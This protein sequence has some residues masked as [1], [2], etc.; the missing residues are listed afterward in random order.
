MYSD[1][2][3]ISLHRCPSGLCFVRSHWTVVC[4][5]CEFCTYE[6]LRKSQTCKCCNWILGFPLLTRNLQKPPVSA[7]WAHQFFQCKSNTDL[8]RYHRLPWTDGM[9]LGIQAQNNLKVLPSMTQMFFGV[10]QS[11]PSCSQLAGKMVLL[12]ALWIFL[13]ISYR[14]HRGLQPSVS[15]SRFIVH[16]TFYNIPSYFLRNKHA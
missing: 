7:Y 6:G 16:S 5:H 9:D 8:L 10:H 14:I 13:Q 1:G 11:R 2:L 12:Y 3:W 4:V 15:P